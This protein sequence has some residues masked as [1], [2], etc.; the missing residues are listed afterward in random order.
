MFQNLISFIYPRICAGCGKV[1]VGGER[2]ICLNCLADLPVTGFED[3]NDNPVAKIFWGRVEITHATAFCHFDKGG[4][5]QHMLHQLKYKGNYNVGQQLGAL[6]GYRLVQSSYFKDI[7]AIVPVPLHPKKEKK[8]GYNQS[9]EIGK[10]VAEIMNKP[11]ILKNLARKKYSET[12]TL[13]GRFERWE[14]VAGIFEIRD[15]IV[16]EGKHLLLIDDVVTSGATL[17]A[18]SQTLLKVKDVRVSIATIAF[19]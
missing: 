4:K 10:G 11:L 7:D 17:E 15:K 18:C 16:L 9:A 8:R 13:K 6:L 12:Q 1:L 19:S 14:N 2:H 3:D 5:L